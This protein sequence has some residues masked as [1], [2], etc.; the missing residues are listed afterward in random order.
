MSELFQQAVANTLPL[1]QSIG[2]GI[3]PT[4]KASLAAL[5]KLQAAAKAASPAPL[6]VTHV[7][8]SI[9]LSCRIGG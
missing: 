3:K 1:L 4:P 9:A 6:T 2:G 5:K 8:A 7:P